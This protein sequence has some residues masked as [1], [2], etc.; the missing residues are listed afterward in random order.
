MKKII[1]I[2]SCIMLLSRPSV[3]GVDCSDYYTD[4][5]GRWTTDILDDM[6]K[7]FRNTHLYIVDSNNKILPSIRDDAVMD[8]AELGVCAVATDVYGLYYDLVTKSLITVQNLAVVPDYV[9]PLHFEQRL[10]ADVQLQTTGFYCHNAKQTI[11]DSATIA[12]IE[13]IPELQ[14]TGDVSISASF[15]LIN[16]EQNG[17]IFQVSSVGESFETNILYGIVMSPGGMLCWFH[18]YAEGVNVKIPSGVVLKPETYYNVVAKRD[19]TNKTI[20]F[21]INNVDGYPISYN[22]NAE[23]SEGFNLQKV[24]IGSYPDGRWAIAGL[25][26]EVKACTPDGYFEY[27]K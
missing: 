25:V 21:R 22:E 20:T 7:D 27:K 23:K 15:V 19:S 17:H 18:E 12:D 13:P 10:D 2:I 5:N 6:H 8:Y 4:P 14:S 16:T 24:A 9:M 11:F 3:F 26:W 1:F